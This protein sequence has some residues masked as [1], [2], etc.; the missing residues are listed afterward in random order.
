MIQISSKLPQTSNSIFSKMTALAV[1]NNAI[2]LSQG[3]PD[4][5]IDPE[6]IKM[7]TKE[8]K[9]GNNQYAPM[10]GILCLRETISKLIEN[11]FDSYYSPQEEI[12]VTAGGTQAIYTAI[13][14][15]IKPND[16]AI[17][18]EPAYDCYAP[19]VK[20]FGG[21]VKYFEMQPPFFDIDWDMVK[22]LVTANTKLIIINSPQNPTGRLLKKE[23]IEQLKIITHN[24]D[25]FIISDEVYGQITFDQ[26]EHLS[27]AKYPELKERT[28]ITASF[29]KVLH[30]TG[31]KIGY[32]LAPENLMKEFRKIHQFL[33]FSVNTPMQY[34]ID[35]YLNKHDLR[36]NLSE[37][38]QNK[39]DLFRTLLKQTN[40]SLLPCEGSYFQNVSYQNISDEKD[41][42]LAMRM[43]KDFKVASIPNSSFYSRN[44]DFKTLR[45]CFA[46]KDETLEQAANLL[47]KI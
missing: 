40:F 17:I 2:N 36:L 26:K 21:L 3:F 44:T 12:T 43:V 42:E 37:F 23:D 25:I 20:V 13:A 8:M 41:V 11:Q 30:C 19:T 46:K 10:P 32:C 47:K 4:F 18:F 7:V 16:E 33:V 29:G 45:F 39:R 34:A 15:I 31:W 24:T 28:F 14:T 35:S 38:Y 5:D 9:N 22:K 27:L 1:K 6:L